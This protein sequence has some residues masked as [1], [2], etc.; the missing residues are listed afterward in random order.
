MSAHAQGAFARTEAQLVLQQHPHRSGPV[1]GGHAT[2]TSCFARV[3]SKSTLTGAI[4]Q[5]APLFEESTWVFAPLQNET[6]IQSAVVT[7][8]KSRCK[9]NEHESGEGTDACPAEPAPAC[10]SCPSALACRQRR[11]TPTSSHTR[12]KRCDT[13]C[14]GS[15]VHNDP[16]SY[17]GDDQVQRSRYFARELELILPRMAGRYL[18]AAAKCMDNVQ[19]G[20]AGEPNQSF[21][22]C[23]RYGCSSGSCTHR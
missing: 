20:R 11:P 8:T 2:S 16:R 17:Q 3:L 6:A 21:D 12:M 5:T 4:D 15:L 10:A 23:S 1:P 19:T 22:S 7:G 14:T 13:F 18:P 9:K